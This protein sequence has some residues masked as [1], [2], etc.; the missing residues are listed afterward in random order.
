MKKKFIIRAVESGELRSDL[1]VEELVN[2]LYVQF[3]GL[4]RVAQDLS[5]DA[6][7]KQIDCVANMLLHMD[8]WGP[9][10]EEKRVDLLAHQKDVWRNDYDGE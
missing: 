9:N 5:L 3:Y 10:A 1:N 4:L 7:L 2:F 6:T 8:I